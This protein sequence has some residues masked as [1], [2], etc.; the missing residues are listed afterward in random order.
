[1]Q[2][3]AEAWPSDIGS[4]EV[5]AD[6]IEEAAEHLLFKIGQNTSILHK[7]DLMYRATDAAEDFARDSNEMIDVFSMAYSDHCEAGYLVQ[8]ILLKGLTKFVESNLDEVQRAYN[9]GKYSELDA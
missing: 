8:K 2:S 1:M 3:L 6:E 9:M 4:D 7:A 5:G